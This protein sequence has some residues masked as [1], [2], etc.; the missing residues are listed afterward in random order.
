[1]RHF[2]SKTVFAMNLAPQKKSVINNWQR[3]FGKNQYDLNTHAALAGNYQQIIHEGDW[4]FEGKFFYNHAE[5][6]M[7]DIFI[8]MDVGNLSL[9]LLS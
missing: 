2:I 4:V 9:V 1:M 8:E 6:P 3:Q 7:V 5:G